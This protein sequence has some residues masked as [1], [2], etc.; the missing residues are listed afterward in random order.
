MEVALGTTVILERTS[1]RM[2][3]LDRIGYDLQRSLV[4]ADALGLFT[5]GVY[6]QRAIDELDAVI[7]SSEDQSLAG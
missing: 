3:A 1:D 7:D 6:V 2:R 5:V 4:R